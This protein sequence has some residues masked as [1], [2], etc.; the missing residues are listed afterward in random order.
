[1]DLAGGI[2]PGPEG[3]VTAP[4]PKLYLKHVPT[5]DIGTSIKTVQ[6]PLAEIAVWDTVTGAGAL[7]AACVH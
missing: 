4:E 2:D 1:M 3:E 5:V 6:R 7:L